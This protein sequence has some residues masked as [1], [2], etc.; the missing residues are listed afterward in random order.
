MVYAE[1]GL[2]EGKGGQVRRQEGKGG[3]G[4]LREVDV[5]QVELAEAGEAGEQPGQEPP[6]FK[7]P[8]MD[9]TE[10]PLKAD[11]FEVRSEGQLAWLL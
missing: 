10:F 1:P 9:L 4:E 11:Y 7:P 2:G 5:A 3:R 6:P 8:C